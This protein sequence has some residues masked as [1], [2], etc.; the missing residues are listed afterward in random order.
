MGSPGLLSSGGCGRAS[1]IVPAGRSALV[2]LVSTRWIVVANAAIMTIATT[3]AKIATVICVRRGLRSLFMDNTFPNTNQRNRVEPVPLAS[4]CGRILRCNSAA[5]VHLPPSPTVIRP[6][7]N[8]SVAIIVVGII[9]IGIWR[10]YPE[11]YEVSEVV[12]VEG[13]TGERAEAC[14]AGD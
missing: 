10:G 5:D 12:M 2:C 13:P 9:R 14:S 8:E 1:P 4:A 6:H 3:A 11:R 7:P